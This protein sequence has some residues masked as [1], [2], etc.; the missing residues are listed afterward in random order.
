MFDFIMF[1]ALGGAFCFRYPSQRHG[2]IYSDGYRYYYKRK[3]ICSLLSIAQID[4]SQN[5]GKVGLTRAQLLRKYINKMEL[6]RHS[7]GPYALP[8]SDINFHLR[9]NSSLQ[10]RFNLRVLDPGNSARTAIAA[11]RNRRR[12]PHRSRPGTLKFPAN[13]RISSSPCALD[14]DQ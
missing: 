7:H 12:R 4:I 6:K 1:E 11:P 3:D 8:N 5:I 2:R 10:L 13:H 14:R 9:L